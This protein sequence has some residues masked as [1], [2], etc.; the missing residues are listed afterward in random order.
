[1]STSRLD[2]L[3]ALVKR[4]RACC[5]SIASRKADGVNTHQ[6]RTKTT[7]R[8]NTKKVRRKSVVRA[9]CCALKN[10]VLGLTNRSNK[11]QHRNRVH[12][13]V[14]QSLNQTFGRS[15]EFHHALHEFCSRCRPTMNVSIWANHGSN[16]FG[17]SDNLH[18]SEL[19]A[20]LRDPLP[21]KF[22]SFSA[23]LNP[24]SFAIVQIE[25]SNV[26]HR[27]KR[28]CQRSH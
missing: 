24:T 7:Y 4:G 10:M 16:I 3:K 11:D 28:W 27:S 15:I 25:A 1:M 2:F 5:N 14:T 8:A 21:Q 19:F 26:V 23:I 13:E 22:T 18:L 20:I 6:V 9:C 17:L 12:L